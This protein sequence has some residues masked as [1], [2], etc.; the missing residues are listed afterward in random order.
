MNIKPLLAITLI[1]LLVTGCSTNSGVTS[2]RQP[3]ETSATSFPATPASPLD[4]SDPNYYDTRGGYPYS[5]SNSLGGQ[6][7]SALPNSDRIVYF[8]FDSFEVRPD[9]RPLIEQQAQ[10]LLANPGSRIIL[11]GHAD[12]RGT[13]EYNIGLG[14]LRGEAVRRLLIALGVPPQQISVI[15]YGEE[16]PAANSHDESSYA[17][18]RRVEMVY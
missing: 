5:D 8:D 1:G 9:Y 13:R 14:E 4:S 10:A 18:N 2:S 17:L 3:G 15:S 6:N 7:V 12:E 11:E 16:R